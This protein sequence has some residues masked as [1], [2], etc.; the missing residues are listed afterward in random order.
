MPVF[1]YASEKASSRLGSDS[2]L[3]QSGFMQLAGA[4]GDSAKNR[5]AQPAQQL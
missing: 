5:L 1:T 4:S 2:R 3:R